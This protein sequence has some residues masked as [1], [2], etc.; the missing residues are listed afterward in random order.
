MPLKSA[1]STDNSFIYNL[2]TPDYSISPVLARACDLSQEIIRKRASLRKV[3]VR[4]GTSFEKPGDIEQ[5][6]HLAHAL[7]G[8]MQET[9]LAIYL[10]DRGDPG[11]TS[12][13]QR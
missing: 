13:A 2:M 12:Y 7:A 4:L 8:L 10:F 11:T 3:Q 5:A 9:K 1:P 6:R